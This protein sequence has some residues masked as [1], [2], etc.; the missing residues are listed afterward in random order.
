MKF[1]LI[2][3]AKENP[4]NPKID[5]TVNIC[6]SSLIKIVMKLLN[7][8]SKFFQFFFFSNQA[9]KPIAIDNEKSLHTNTD[10]NG[11]A[12]LNSAVYVVLFRV[13]YLSIMSQTHEASPSAISIH[14]APA[15]VSWLHKSI[16]ARIQVQVL[17]LFNFRTVFCYHCTLCSW[18]P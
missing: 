11:F 6:Q 18:N 13:Q 9:N 12:I 15:S 2:P 3:F 1:V 16:P 8:S 5:S 17:I 14:E 4:K 7:L 10:V